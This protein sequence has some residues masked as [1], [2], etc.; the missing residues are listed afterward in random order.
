MKKGNI[1][2]KR[3]AMAVSVSIIMLVAGIISLFTLPVEQYPDIAPPTV[4]VA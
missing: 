4:Y 3:P 1:F 2:I